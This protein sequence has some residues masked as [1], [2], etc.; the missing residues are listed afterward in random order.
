MLLVSFR[1]DFYL[2]VEYHI[3]ITNFDDIFINKFDDFLFLRK[4]RF[5]RKCKGERER[6]KAYATRT[7]Y[8]Q[9]I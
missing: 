5:N 3:F 6:E 9:V 4:T 8:F 2:Y 7:S 1:R